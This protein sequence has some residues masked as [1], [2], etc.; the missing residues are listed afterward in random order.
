[1]VVHLC[2]AEGKYQKQP[3]TST[4]VTLLNSALTWLV[5]YRMSKLL[6]WLFR[7]SDVIAMSGVIYADKSIIRKILVPGWRLHYAQS[8]DLSLPAIY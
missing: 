5:R 3:K 1:M 8:H 2:M 6:T 4:L 7:S